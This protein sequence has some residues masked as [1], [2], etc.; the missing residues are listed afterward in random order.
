MK[1]ACSVLANLCKL[2]KGQEHGHGLD[3]GLWGRLSGILEV[4]MQG[5]ANG[6]NRFGLSMT[7]VIAFVK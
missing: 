6:Y 2:I 5:V 1:D 7:I 3:T 4:L